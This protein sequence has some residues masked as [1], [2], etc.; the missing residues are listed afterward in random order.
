MN[1]MALVVKC[2]PAASYSPTQSPVQY[3]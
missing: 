2:C 1:A 3:H